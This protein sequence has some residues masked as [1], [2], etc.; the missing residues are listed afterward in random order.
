VTFETEASVIP[1]DLLPRFKF[2]CTALHRA[3]VLLLRR[4]RVRGF[5]LKVILTH[6]LAAEIERLRPSSDENSGSYTTKRLAGTVVA[7]TLCPREEGELY[8]VVADDALWA[9]GDDETLA[10]GIAT[11]AHELA[12]CAIESVRSASVC[13]LFED[14]LTT[15]E[16][17]AREIVR[18]ALDEYRADMIE[19]VFLQVMAD[20]TEGGEIGPLQLHHLFGRGFT[21]GLGTVLSDEVYPGWPDRVQ[22]FREWEVPLDDMW[23][24]LARSGWGVF[25]A[26]A[27]ASS[28]ARTAGE[29]DPITGEFAW[30]PAVTLY[31]REP[32]CCLLEIAHAFRPVCSASAHAKMEARAFS[33]GVDAVLGMWSKLGLSFTLNDD[34]ST[35]I[36]VTEPQRVS[37]C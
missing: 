5:S 13:A 23:T 10:N 17:A 32:W 25:V 27:H 18:A 12:H 24:G 6:N 34:G 28:V 14:G 30:H 4:S 3:T 1:P 31:L 37:D 16:M 11:I 9:E 36:G 21:D 15:G 22:A 33:E 29:P 35:Y 7:K 20:A 8:T 19:D 26:I 2:F